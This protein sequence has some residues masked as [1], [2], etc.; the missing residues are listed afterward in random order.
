MIEGERTPH[1]LCLHPLLARMRKEADMRAITLHRQHGPATPLA[2]G[3]EPY[4]TDPDTWQTS[5]PARIAR[6]AGRHWVM[7]RH[8]GEFCQPLDIEGLEALRGAAPPALVIA[9]HTS[10]FDTI[11]VLSALPERIRS[12]T[13]VAAAADRFYRLSRRGWWYSLFY[14]TFPIDRHGGGSAT[15]A[16]PLSLLR[17]GWCVLLYPEGTRSTN[18]EIA[19]FHHGVTLMAQQ[20]GVP[21]I[22]VYTEGLR[23]IMP[24]GQRSPTPGPVR[25][26][27]GAP[28]SLDG[29]GSVPEGT[30]RLEDAMRSLAGKPGAAPVAA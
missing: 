1:Q 14:N 4:R 25:V 5:L 27:V 10:H 11:V 18:G 30:A 16:Y 15:L 2:Q 24:K 7:S 8:I 20:A 13:A 22:P 26:R 29:V 17:G 23:A 21:V 12:R 3:D 9:N 19:P 28:V 6:R